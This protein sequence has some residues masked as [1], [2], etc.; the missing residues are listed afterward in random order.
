VH[1]GLLANVAL[2]FGLDDKGWLD[3]STGISPVSYPVPN[4]PAAVWRELPNPTQALKRAA[5]AYYG[6]SDILVTSGS[7]NVIQVL[8]KL[9]HF[10][11][12]SQTKVLVPEVGYKEHEKSW[13]D[14][15]FLVVRYRQIPKVEELEENS[16]LV[17]INP[18]N[19]SGQLVK[20]ATLQNLHQRLKQI[21]G[22]LI[23][24]EAF[25][26]LLPKSHSIISQANQES[27]FVLRSIGKFFGL[28]GIRVGFV[29][30]QSYY[31]N[32]IAALLGPW[33]VNGPAL[34]ICEK[35][36]MD[37]PWQLEQRRY[38]K[39]QSSR[40]AQVIQDCLKGHN[41]DFLSIDITQT[42]LFVTINHPLAT[43]IYRALCKQK[44]YVRLCDDKQ[45][46]RVGIP[47]NHEFERLAKGL[48]RS[49]KNVLL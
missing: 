4:I 45:A 32:K 29:A 42:D 23:V 28:A 20:L 12:A 15:G 40:L 49:F 1:G 19:P 37:R 48:S 27:L 47:N 18:N 30:C 10:K 22:W 34:Y 35:A 3:L 31:L 24:D 43:G 11:P 26:D 8:P 44:I 39:A 41:F 21:N 38:L 13:I 2:E 46:I 36:L 14:N 9:W 16:I 33:Q 17:I 25:I 7:Q 5:N 6:A